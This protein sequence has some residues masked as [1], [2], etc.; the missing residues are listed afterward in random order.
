[1]DQ[2]QRNSIKIKI[3]PNTQALLKQQFLALVKKQTQ[4]D[5]MTPMTISAIW[6]MPIKTLTL[7]INKNSTQKKMML[8]KMHSMKKKIMT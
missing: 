8:N 5:L 3:H 2:G 7:L 1:M 6:N 4:S